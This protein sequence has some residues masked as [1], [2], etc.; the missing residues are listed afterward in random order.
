MERADPVRWPERHSY[1]FA[2]SG[3]LSDSDVRVGG[4]R[5]ASFTCA[6]SAGEPKP[7]G[8]RF[9]RAGTGQ[10]QEVARVLSCMALLTRKGSER[11]IQGVGYDLPHTNRIASAMYG[12]GVR[13]TF[14]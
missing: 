8:S 11:L 12:G 3:D 14:G 4:D 9:A 7:D 5:D 13:V 1:F 2:D 6:R 10:K